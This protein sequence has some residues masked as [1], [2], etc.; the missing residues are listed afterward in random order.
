VDIITNSIV[1][2]TQDPTIKTVESIMDV[3][4]SEKIEG[5]QLV[6]TKG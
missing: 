2:K 3:P 4:E 5:R 6:D 1:D